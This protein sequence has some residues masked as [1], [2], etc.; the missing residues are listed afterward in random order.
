VLEDNRPRPR[1]RT[2]IRP[3]RGGLHAVPDRMPSPDEARRAMV[4]AVLSV[5]CPEC[6][7]PNSMGCDTG[8]KGTS[9]LIPLSFDGGHAL[10]AH[11]DRAVT[12]WMEE[13]LTE[14]ELNA[15]LAA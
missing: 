14:P 7:R 5:R 13:R 8:M 4:A 10:A 6:S 2:G 12:A 15:V 11:A 3:Q 9:R 1:K